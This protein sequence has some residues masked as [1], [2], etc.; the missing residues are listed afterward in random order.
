[1]VIVTDVI[2]PVVLPSAGVSGRGRGSAATRRQPLP[3]PRLAVACGSAPMVIYRVAAIDSKG[4]VNDLAVPRALGWDSGTRLDMR[5]TSGLLLVSANRQGVFS[6]T[7][8]GYLRVPVT[9]RRWCGLQTA[10][11]VLVTADLDDGL[12]VVHP[13]AACTAM[14]SLAYAAVRGGA[15]V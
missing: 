1:V 13:P 4:R 7:K 9:V 5:E 8:E 12:L 6:L 15:G 2:A 14:I 10:D 11:R 3:M